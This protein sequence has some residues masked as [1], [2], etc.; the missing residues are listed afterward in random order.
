MDVDG[1]NSYRHSEKWFSVTSFD[2]GECICCRVAETRLLMYKILYE[3][4][5]LQL[6]AVKR[7][8]L[9]VFWFSC[10]FPFFIYACSSSPALTFVCRK[11]DGYWALEFRS[12]KCWS[13]KSIIYLI[14]VQG[15]LK[16]TNVFINILQLILRAYMR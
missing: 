12:V 9:L 7:D 15:M 14:V 11:K 8:I 10:A 3:R 4:T 2:I 13:W 1:I 6:M 16:F 5:K